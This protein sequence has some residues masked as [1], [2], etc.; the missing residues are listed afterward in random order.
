MNLKAV[1][2]L[3]LAVVLGLVAAVLVK[4]AI[5]HRD[6]TTAAP[7]NL[8]TVVVAKQDCDPGHALTAD[9][10]AV[11]K[12]PADAAPG[13]I[14][15]DPTQ[16]DGR[17]TTTPLLK[18]QTILETLLAPTGTGAGLQ[19]LIPPGMRAFTI[20]VNDSS[21]VGGM[22]TPGCRVDV[23]TAIND[24]KVNNVIARTVLQNIKVTAVGRVVSNAP[25]Q[26]G[27]PPA[28][29]SSNV[30][31]LLTPQQSQ[32]MEL[33]TLLS[34]PWLVLR[35]TR[36]TAA[37]PVDATSLAELKGESNSAPTTEPSFAAA[38]AA[39]APAPTTEP[40]AEAT[41]AP[42][43]KHVVQV[44]HGDTEADVTFVQHAPAPAPAPETAGLDTQELNR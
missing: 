39:A 43:I 28:P 44:L 34:R 37:D 4:N 17:V 7:S 36:D 10:L 21:S 18:G 33:A 41:P 32:I 22:L 20:D 14:F 35:S 24:P 11:S 27:A 13:Q 5:A 15:S 23:L 25:P 9:D 16:L 29:P 40:V 19:A 3:A 8:V 12:M 2:P 30:T 6:V 31:L 1:V 26:P 38:N 42:L